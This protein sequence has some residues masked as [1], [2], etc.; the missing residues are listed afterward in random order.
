MNPKISVL[1]PVFNREK[2][3]RRAIGSIMRQTYQ[4]LEIIV[5]DDGSTDNSVHIIQDLMKRDSR[6]R[7]IQGY[8]NR[9]VGF[10]RNQLLGACN[11]KIACWH[12]SDDISYPKRIAQ[13]FAK[14]NN[15]PCLVF[16]HW[17]WITYHKKPKKWSKYL[18]RPTHQKSITIIWLYYS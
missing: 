3:I 7:L 13:Q 10:A 14:M 9:G 11:T 6:I 12:D 4:N 15:E 2:Y 16:C 5:Y 1:I 8:E 17:T 18:N